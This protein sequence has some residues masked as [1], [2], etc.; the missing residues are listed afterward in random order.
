M[1]YRKE[2][3]K[4][5]TERNRLFKAGKDTNPF[6]KEFA[7]KINALPEA[8]RNAFDKVIKQ[9]EREKLEKDLKVLKEEHGIDIEI[10]KVS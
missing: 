3:E 7:N 6:I 2:Y 9:I 5:L 1:D 8:E 4:F 10:P